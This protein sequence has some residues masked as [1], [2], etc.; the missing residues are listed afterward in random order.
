MNKYLVAVLCKGKTDYI[1][2]GTGF[3]FGDAN[4]VIT[5]KH[6]FMAEGVLRFHEGDAV[7][8]QYRE[9]IIRG[10]LSKISSNEDIAIIVVNAHKNQ[11]FYTYSSMRRLNQG[12]VEK[13]IQCMCVGFENGIT[14][15][16]R[17][18]AFPVCTGEQNGR[19]ILDN[20]N[21]IRRG[22]SGAPLETD[23][24]CLLGMV[25]SYDNAIDGRAN[26]IANAVPI[27]RIYDLLGVKKP[28]EIPLYSVIPNFSY[29]YN[30]VKRKFTRKKP[31]EYAELVGDYSDENACIDAYIADGDERASVLSYLEKW[32]CGDTFGT[33]LIHGEPGHGKTLLCNKAVF[34]YC[35]GNFLMNKATNVL[36]VSL[37]TGDNSRIIIDGRV[38]LKNALTWAGEDKTFTF[39]DCR[40]ALLFMDGYDEFIDEAKK[41]D[42]KNIVSFM[43]LIDEI[44]DK[45]G[46]HIVVLSR[47]IA[48]GGYLEELGVVGK[49][50]RL[51]SLTDEQQ[52]NWLNQHSEY[53]DYMETFYILRE[54]ANMRE[55]LEIPFLFRLIVQSRF[56]EVSTNVV[57]LY[58]KLFKH[59]MNKRNI[60]DLELKSVIDSLEKLA[61]SIY[62]DDTDTA[63]ISKKERDKRWLIAFY[64]K[65]SK[66]GRVGFYHRS[67]YQYFLTRFI[68]DGILKLTDNQ[69]ETYIS[70]FAERELDKTVRH[71]LS[72]MIEEKEKENVYFN[73]NYAVD[74]LVRTEAYLSF[75]P[76]CLV[77]DAERK[78]TIRSK[79]IFRNTLIICAAFGYVIQTPFK[80]QLDVFLRIYT[81]RGIWL[82][83]YDNQR[84]N[85]READLNGAD[86]SRSHLR[87]ADLSG[88][89]LI[90]ANLSKT[91]LRGT[92]LSGADLSGA[93][94]I[95]ADLSRAKLSGAKLSGANLSGANLSRADLSGAD[96]G[97]VNLTKADLREANVR[98][99][100]LRQADL[101]E[102]HLGK[103]ELRRTDLS[104]ADLSRVSL[105]GADLNGANLSRTYLNMAD[106]NGAD[107]RKACLIRADLSK[108][109]LSGAD[110]SGANLKFHRAGNLIINSKYNKYI[111][112]SVE[113]YDRIQWI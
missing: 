97:E 88:A 79:N 82:C 94:L 37:N 13:P 17:N 11:S 45:N 93:D 83:S 20:A 77:G 101:K 99:A 69:A 6:N 86:L 96:M 49:S 54:N 3:F 53:D 4:H 107:L 29:F 76:R 70:Y 8:L 40:G 19:L 27:E 26:N 24:R 10:I 12:I 113:G 28:K 21:A 43:K 7:F 74:A 35:K 62:C 34:E 59:L 33:L 25:R 31:K 2:I 75:E 110:L 100:D 66:I 64:L 14:Y 57:E 81:S 73:L 41:A 90:E 105:I 109:D 104:G 87:E 84:V 98:E 95:E 58:G 72:L 92:D 5:C 23:D 46:I 111:D 85:L 42:I 102:A 18:N 52:D 39:Q 71:Y 36:M 112:S 60:F 15:E 67:F 51:L 108:A 9:E 63:L 61:Y 56:N 32:F 22:F 47:T 50:Y 38:V 80:E 30:D 55:L 89:N 1:V 78:K 65:Q 91:D 103:A 16:R 44:A 48:V 68:Y 106:L